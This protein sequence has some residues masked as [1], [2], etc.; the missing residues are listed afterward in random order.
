MEK[1][2]H[3]EDMTASELKDATDMLNDLGTE[4]VE[5]CLPPHW[6]AAPTRTKPVGPAGPQWFMSD[7]YEEPT[8]I[9]LSIQNNPSRMM[10]VDCGGEKGEDR[11]LAMRLSGY[12]VFPSTPRNSG[13]D[14]TY[15][16]DDTAPVTIMWM[17]HPDTWSSK[18]NNDDIQTLYPRKD[19]GEDIVDSLLNGAQLIEIRIGDLQY[20]FA[21][22]GFRQAS[23]PLLDFCYP[24]SGDTPASR[25][26]L[27]LINKAR[28][29]A[30]LHSV[31]L[32]NNEA[33]QKHA[34]S[35][36][37]HGFT[38]H[39]GLDGLTAVMRYTLAGG[40]NYVAQNTSGVRG[41]RDA[42]WGPQ[43][44]QRDWRLSLEETHQGLL[45]SS[46][47]RRNILDKWH[48]K[49]SLGIACNKYTCSVVQNFEGDYV[50]FTKPPS[51]SDVGVLT[52]AGRLKGGFTLSNVQVWYHQPPHTLTLGQLDATYSDSL[53]QEPA[54]TIIEP[55]PPGTSYSPSDLL[56]VN[57]TWLSGV[58]PYSVNPQAPRDRSS[59]L[60]IPRIIIP[61]KTMRKALPYTVADRWLQGRSFDIKVDIRKII[62]ST[63]PGV[64]I[65]VIWGTNGEEDVHLTNYA[66]SVD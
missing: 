8:A 4:L 10:V 23:K 16:I 43:Y 62:S 37:Q 55:A 58:D 64:Y 11:W 27:N 50:D 29:E 42:D 45:D 24:Q 25:V 49:V 46:A 21:T 44:F 52:L 3:V 32:G 59:A 48:K 54:T 33:A 17:P 53:G 47:H 40:T 63:G 20:S 31:T 15:T 39:W 35:M 60:G 41:I 66:I 19:V 13:V 22:K 51:I 26:M 18:T 9:L 65:I 57:Y 1:R 2:G 36:L 12:Q 56:P 28:W 38:G 7:S 34:E 6:K 61:S 14:L 5:T 30:G